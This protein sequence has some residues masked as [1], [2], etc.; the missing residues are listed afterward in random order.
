[1]RAPVLPMRRTM[2]LTLIQYLAP[3]VKKRHTCSMAE[4]DGPGKSTLDSV[5]DFN[6]D[7][8]YIDLQGTRTQDQDDVQQPANKTSSYN[9]G[10]KRRL[11]DSA[12]NR[13]D[14]S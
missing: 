11:M 9:C 8:G 13:G 12:P 5:R 14:R 10:V 2:I 1:M 3:V 7:L 6:R 4:L